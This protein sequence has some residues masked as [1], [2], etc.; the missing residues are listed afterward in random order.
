MQTTPEMPEEEL[1]RARRFVA[2]LVDSVSVFGL[3]PKQA[4]I[5]ITDSGRTA[6]I[7]DL[8]LAP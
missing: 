6:I 5:A 8:H 1:A 4:Q 2:V 3:R 7:M